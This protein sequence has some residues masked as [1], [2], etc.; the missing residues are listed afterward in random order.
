VLVPQGK[1]REELLS[2]R[3]AHARRC[4]AQQLGEPRDKSVPERVLRRLRRVWPRAQCEQE[5]VREEGERE[6]RSAA[7]ILSR[8]E[9]LRTLKQRVAERRRSRAILRFD[10]LARA[11]DRALGRVEPRQK[12]RKGQARVAHCGPLWRVRDGAVRERA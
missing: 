1:E 3:V 10:P 5:V 7:R 8:R 2:L 12:R 4:R 11:D 6:A 9:L